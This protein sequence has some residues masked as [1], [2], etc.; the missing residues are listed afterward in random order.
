MLFYKNDISELLKQ[1]QSDVSVGLSQQ[2]AAD[3]LKKFGQN[4]MMAKTSRKWWKIMFAQFNNLLVILLVIA[5]VLSFQLG[6]NRDGIVLAIIVVANALIGFYQD[7]KSENILQSLKNLVAEKCNVLRNG[8]VQQIPVE[9]VVPGDVVVIHEGDGVSA[10][11][12]L[13]ESH[14]LFVNEFILTGESE[15][16]EKKHEAVVKDDA[17]MAEQSN[18]IFMG[19]TVAKG[20]A[21]G[22][23]VATGMQ[24]E[25]GKIAGKSQEIKQDISPLQKEIN[26]VAKKITIITLI[27]GVALF[28]FSRI[29]GEA[30][31]V[32]LVFAISIAAAMVPEGLPAQISIALALGVRRLAKKKAVVKQLSSVEALGSATVIAS[33]K[34]GTITKNEM[35]INN[36]VFNGE[37][38]TV[39]GTGYNPKGQVFNEAMQ[40]LEQAPLHEHKFFFT[41]GYLSSISSVNPPDEFHPT[42][43]GIG[44]PTESAFC[45]LAMKAGFE[46]V[47]LEKE[48]PR[49][50]LFPFDSERKR[51]SIIRG[52]AGK[53]IA[54]VKGSIESILEVSEQQI[55]HGEIKPLTADQKKFLLQ[56]AE[57]FAA[58]SLRVIAIAY[59]ELNQANSDKYTIEETES[60][61]VFAGFA[62]MFDPP[63]DEVPQAIQDAFNAH[64]RIIIITGDNE[65]TARAI[66]KN[67]GLANADNSLPE[68]IT[69]QRLGT[70]NDADIK[71]AL[72]QRTLVFSRVSP[73]D[74][75][76]IVSLLKEMGE[77]VA[78]TGDGVNDTLSLKKADIG[79]AM[80]QNGSKVAQEAAEMVLLNDNFSTI[81]NAIK[82][83]RTIFNNIR[84]NVI[85]TLASNTAELI[86]V[87]YGFVGVYFHQP[88]VIL[89]IHILLIDLIGEMLPLLMLTFD[90]AGEDLMKAHPRKKG[91]LLNS[92]LLMQVLGSGVARGVLAIAVFHFIFHLHNG[93]E[94]RH[95]IAVTG[96]FITIILT[97]FINI[98][99][100]RTKKSMFDK[101]LFSNTNLL[102]GMAVSL[103]AMFVIIYTPFFNLYLHTGAL[104]IRDWIFPLA[105]SFI[106]MACFELWKWVKNKRNEGHT[107]NVLEPKIHS[108]NSLL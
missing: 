43:Y 22:L 53:Q 17:A 63:R 46:P 81:V 4:K 52:N 97:Q 51:V 102:W 48:F 100:I 45:T 96:T 62:T 7:W 89:A 40:P 6:S 3:N 1:L 88:V 93:E 82:E 26:L 103:V 44:D 16:S 18:M 95:P 28:I 10:D 59:K 34:T 37:P 27:L 84:K 94:N 72:L 24:T 64:I 86:C 33:D 15:S 54:F 20:E 79:V 77:V 13:L 55:V 42:W 80:G 71:Q 50:L 2:K 87:L 107:I 104:T 19:T 67:I 91:E 70:M 29:Q 11:M 5:S 78:V 60:N 83:G 106:Y 74:K 73:D 98:F 76:K 61:L 14:S 90:T 92:S 69:Q 57:T 39:T 99:C 25:I 108:T 30:I 58:D 9:D 41:A 23:V 49:L 36:C 101:F 85:A 56:N 66:A 32:A 68:V 105:A 31:S 75:L 35:S 65:M 38:F 8:K 47:A 21:K 12:R